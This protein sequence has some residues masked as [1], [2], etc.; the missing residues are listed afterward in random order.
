MYPSMP[1]PTIDFVHKSEI[2]FILLN[3]S[4]LPISVIWTSIIGTGSIERA[5]L[6][7][8]LEW[9]KPPGLITTPLTSVSFLIS[10]MY[11][12]ISP[13]EFD[14]KNSILFLPSVCSVI[15]FFKSSY[16]ILPYF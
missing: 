3:D 5:S 7:E 15:L 14:W 4:L 16:D 11:V 8:T 2:K 12:T 6:K 1:F 9:V 13:S 10:C